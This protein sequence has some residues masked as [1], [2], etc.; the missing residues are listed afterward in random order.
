ML[1]AA[2]DALVSTQNPDGGW[3]VKPG[4]QSQTEATSFALLA[5]SIFHD[6]ALNERMDQGLKWL[7]ERQKGDGSWPLM[8]G[9]HE[10]SW[11]TAIAIFSLAS[12]EAYRS[13]ALRGAG[14]LLRQ[15]GRKLGWM[16]SLLYRLAP[17]QMAIC[18]NPDLQGWSW[19][20]NTYSWVE[21]TASALMALKKARA[22]LPETPVEARIGEGERLLYDRMCPEGGWNYG[23]TVVLGERLWPYP[24][25]TA[26]TLIALQDHQREEANQQSLQ[27]LRR[28]VAEVGSGLTLSWSIL[29]FSLYGEDVT[30]LQK[31]LVQNFTKTRFLGETKTMALALLALENGAEVFRL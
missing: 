22:S 15:K 8:A 1:Q 5:L 31:R 19:T 17:Q 14:W 27:A 2:L 4:Q 6:P 21:P 24:D 7:I 29:C 28:M 23:N 30:A 20:P 11:T 3:G 10:S 26:L 25:I 9:L 13:Q 16:A 18:L 12:F